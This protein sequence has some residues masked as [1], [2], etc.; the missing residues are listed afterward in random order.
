M[1]ALASHEPHFAL[2]REEGILDKRKAAK[3]GESQEFHL[4]HIAMVRDYLGLE[5][6]PL[7]EEGVLPFPFD[8]ERCIDDWFDLPLPHLP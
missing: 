4:L 8:L 7:G 5:F 2:L 3:K 6:E 1:L